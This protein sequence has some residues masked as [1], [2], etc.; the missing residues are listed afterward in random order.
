M[1]RRSTFFGG[2]GLDWD[3]LRMRLSVAEAQLEEGAS[4][5][6][7]DARVILGERARALARPIDAPTNEDA[8]EV[9][10]FLVGEEMYAVALEHVV[11]VARGAGITPLPGAEWPVIG[12][13]GW[14][15]RI[16]AVLDVSSTARS[17]SEPG[18]ESRILVL[19]ERRAAIGVVASAIESVRRVS[20]DSVVPSLDEP[21]G[22]TEYVLGMTNDA[23]VMLDV[24]ALIQRFRA[25]T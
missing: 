5:S 7:E 15:G 1:T 13:T 20:A 11:E 6:A 8:S 16:L 4:M 18:V 19:G 14:R 9:I 21:A 3:S 10:V 17:H 12:V 23:I 2:Q 25:D 24:P 22:R